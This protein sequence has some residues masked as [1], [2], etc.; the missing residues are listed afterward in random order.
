MYMCVWFVERHN[1][2]TVVWASEASYDQNQRLPF[3]KLELNYTIV[4][5]RI[6]LWF[7]KNIILR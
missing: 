7:E 6:L 3:R 5:H 2:M 4:V 1:H